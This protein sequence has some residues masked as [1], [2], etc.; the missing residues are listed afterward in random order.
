MTIRILCC[1]AACVLLLLPASAQ[2]SVELTDR[3]AVDR[4]SLQLA[5]SPFQA[6]AVSNFAE[7][8]PV[9]IERRAAN[10][11]STAAGTAAFG[12]RVGSIAST[13]LRVLAAQNTLT[14]GVPDEQSMDAY[15]RPPDEGAFGSGATVFGQ[16]KEMYDDVT[17]YRT[18]RYDLSIDPLSM[19]CRLKIRLSGILS[20]GSA[21]S[22][23]ANSS[24]ALE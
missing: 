9:R 16:A 21:T 2:R 18:D 8:I 23:R 22:S 17:T 11:A 14:L 4:S 10:D 5:A 19:R 3:A 1:A 13:V 24:G 12:R 15:L 7:S 6:S 20:A